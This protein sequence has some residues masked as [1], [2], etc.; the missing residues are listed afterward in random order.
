MQR[1]AILVCLDGYSPSYLRAAGDNIRRLRRE[2][3]YSE[4]GKAVVPTV[5]NVNNVSI[6]TGTYPSEHGITSNCFYDRE[7][8]IEVYMESSQ[9][10]TAPTIF[11]KLNIKGGVNV[12][13]N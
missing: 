8:G 13:Y 5:T 6:V 4:F 7:K 1:K 10:I 11:E 2:G 3:Y 12:N 9:S